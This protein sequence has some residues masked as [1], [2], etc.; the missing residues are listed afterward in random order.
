MAWNQSLVNQASF[1]VIFF[2]CPGLLPLC[3]HYFSLMVLSPAWMRRLAKTKLN[4]TPSSCKQ[5]R[6]WH[7]F[8]VFV[9]VWSFANYRAGCH[10]VSKIMWS[11]GPPG[12]DPIA[13]WLIFWNGRVPIIREQVPSQCLV[14]SDCDLASCSLIY[15]RWAL[16]QSTMRVTFPHH[17]FLINASACHT[18]TWEHWVPDTAWHDVCVPRGCHGHGLGVTADPWGGKHS[19]HYASSQ[20]PHMCLWCE[21]VGRGPCC[22]EKWGELQDHYWHPWPGTRWAELW[23]GQLV[24]RTWLQWTVLD[25]CLIIFP[26]LWRQTLSAGQTSQWPSTLARFGWVTVLVLMSG[27]HAMTSIYSWYFQAPKTPTQAV[28]SEAQGCSRVIHPWG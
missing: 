12:R 28:H 11:L 5:V 2:P 8:L 6:H 1:T 13:P 15:T 22:V 26:G 27:R 9:G 20:E 7:E 23:Q 21:G 19:C 3:P 4:L 18:E 16:E 14:I 17:Y 25:L 24:P 10:W